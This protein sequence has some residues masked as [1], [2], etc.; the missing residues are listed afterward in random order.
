[1]VGGGK[2]VGRVVEVFDLATQTWRYGP[3]LPTPAGLD[4]SVAVQHGETFIAV[5]GAL[6]KGG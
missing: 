6:V 2:D 1:M 3:Q 4:G 5:G